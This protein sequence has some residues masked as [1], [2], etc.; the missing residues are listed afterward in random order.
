MR[1]RIIVRDETFEDK[2]GVCKFIGYVDLAESIGAQLFCYKCI[3][4]DTD[5]RPYANDPTPG[6]RE[7]IAALAR[8][9]HRAD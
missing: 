5:F 3:F 9:A 6:R 7:A 2:A 1:L 8:D 4:I